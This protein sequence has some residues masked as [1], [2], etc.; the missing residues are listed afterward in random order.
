MFSVVVP[1]YNK[2]EYVLDTIQS[3]LNQSYNNFE[4]IIVNDGST[5]SSL[6]KLSS[7]KDKRIKLV[8]IENSGVS[9]A[10]NVGIE[11]ASFKWV[12]FIDADDLWNENYL[13]E[14]SKI[15]EENPSLKVLST[16]YI[17]RAGNTNLVAMSFPSGY[18]ESY[19]KTPC[20]FSSS[21]IIH[22][23]VFDKV[24]V[25]PV[26][27]KYGEDLH[28]WFRIADRYKIYFNSNP[29]VV[30]NA[31]QHYQTN[32]SY[33]KKDITK[34][35]LYHINDL[36]ISNSEW[37]LFKTIYLL[38]YLRPYYIC[39]NHLDTV[40]KLLSTVR[41]NSRLCLFYKLPRII[42]APLYR[43]IFSHRYRS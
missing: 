24:G 17:R 23:T 29:L 5:D 32:S 14:A 11:N 9:N 31:L 12:A 38:K 18:I 39:D 4:I 16:N 19:F 6:I 25:F 28:L 1:L 15:I 21:I 37:Q 27:I 34:D 36:E 30:Y 41:V 43:V 8:N 20:I 7:I 3:V 33:E 35:V 26:A 22:K 40:R 2:E 13:Y 10:R 42:V